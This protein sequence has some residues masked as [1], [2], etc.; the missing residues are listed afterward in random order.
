MKY[1]YSILSGI[2][3][4]SGLLIATYPIFFNDPSIAS[5]LFILILLIG[6]YAATSLSTI[7]KARIG[8]ISGL[9]VSVVLILY[10]MLHK[11]IVPVSSLTLVSSLIIPGFTMYIGGLIAKLKV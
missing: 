8:L 1:R 4:V 3:I 11:K 9:G 6:G 5:I 7:K 10:F 2:V